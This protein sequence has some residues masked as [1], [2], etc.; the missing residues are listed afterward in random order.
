MDNR[1]QSLLRLDKHQ[2]IAHIINNEYKTQLQEPINALYVATK[3]QT[4][5]GDN[6][7]SMFTFVLL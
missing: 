2:L 7:M 3:A 6:R 1:I 5:I 4:N